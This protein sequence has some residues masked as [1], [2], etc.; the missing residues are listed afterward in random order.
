MA[1]LPFFDLS[2]VDTD[3]FEIE[4]QVLACERVVG[5]ERDFGLGDFHDLDGDHLAFWAL[6]LQLNANFH[7]DVVRKLCARH[8]LTGGRVQRAISL[9]ARDFRNLLFACNHAVDRLVKA[10]DNHARTERELKR[11]APLG[12]IKD[13]T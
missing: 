4:R 6:H 11:I 2:R 13:L 5:V 1:P 7:R 3:H 9:K 8:R 10:G 12:A